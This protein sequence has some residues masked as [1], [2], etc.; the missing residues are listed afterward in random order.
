M[1][2]RKAVPTALKKLRGNPGR[3]PLNALEPMPKRCKPAPP[4]FADELDKELW[5]H[6]T[7]VLDDM[8]MLTEA[9]YFT[10]VNLTNIEKQ[11]LLLQKDIQTEGFTVTQMKM[12]S[13]GNEIQEVKGNP[14]VTQLHRL[15]S[16]YIRYSVLFGL[17]PSS[18]VRLK[19]NKPKE[20]DPLEDFL[21]ES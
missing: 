9:D 11:I 3:R 19:S 5:N 21:G 20:V 7:T 12:D 1:R 17:D 16:V 4:P 14:K 18:R 8:G 15:Y 13:L 6:Y 10:L 2:G